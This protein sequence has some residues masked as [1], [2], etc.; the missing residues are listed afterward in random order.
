MWSAAELLL[1]PHP[2]GQLAEYTFDIAIA[3][4][5]LTW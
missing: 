3:E 2:Q 4:D 5:V 1:H